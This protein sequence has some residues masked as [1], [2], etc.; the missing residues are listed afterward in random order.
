MNPSAIYRPPLGA[1]VLPTCTTIPPITDPM[2]KHWRQPDLTK[3]DIGAERVHLTQQEFD[4][5]LEYSTSMP[6]G[7]YPGKCWKAEELVMDSRGRLKTTGN[8]FLRWFGESDDPR[9]C[10]N[11]QRIITFINERKAA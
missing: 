10:T 4:G 5:L 6:S 8:W 1:A 3:L 7:V 2:G 9:L 11:N